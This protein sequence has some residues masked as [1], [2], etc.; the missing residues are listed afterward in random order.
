MIRKRI[1]GPRRVVVCWKVEDEVAI[2]PALDPSMDPQAYAD[3]L[4]S[5]EL[6]RVQ[7]GQSP[8]WYTIRPLTRRMRNACPSSSGSG[9]M[10]WWIRC[11]LVKLEGYVLV[12]ESGAE[13]ALELE[14]VDEP[15]LSSDGAKVAIVSEATLDKMDMVGTVRA[16]LFGMI[17]H[18]T[19]AGQGPLVKPFAPQLGRTE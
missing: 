18:L 19:E 7:E 10:D 17:K 15:L 8:T 6:V 1:V 12:D 3:S 5:E 9:V 13:T 4:F 2:D 14:M 11:G 16:T